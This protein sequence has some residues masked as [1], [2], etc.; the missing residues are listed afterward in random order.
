MALADLREDVRAAALALPARAREA[1]V[2]IVVT[3]TTRTPAEQDRLC[4]TGYS[5]LCGGTSAHTMGLAFDVALV[6]RDGR[7]EWPTT[8]EG[9]ERWTR[10]G[11]LGEGLGMVWGGRWSPPDW[12]HFQ[13]RDAQQ[14]VNA[15]LARRRDGGAIVVAF[16][17]LVGV[18][19]AARRKR[20]RMRHA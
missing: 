17:V 7:P 8:P 3:S 11:D 19:L 12:P 13:A 2:P 15:R 16:A 20:A 4:R 6:G 5:R 14:R 18:A 9:L 1:G 10:V